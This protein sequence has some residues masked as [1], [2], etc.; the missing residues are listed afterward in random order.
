MISEYYELIDNDKLTN[1]KAY[2]LV[3]AYEAALNKLGRLSAQ[4]KKYRLAAEALYSGLD[5]I[6][7]DTP[8]EN[9]LRQAL[10]DQALAAGIKPFK[11]QEELLN[12]RFGKNDWYLLRT[13][14]E[15]IA[16]GACWNANRY[17]WEFEAV[18]STIE[19]AMRKLMDYTP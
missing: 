17:E 2:E 15:E 11:S 12:D 13:T 5:L 10:L 16:V 18:D 3:E 19:G 14:G 1:E 6:I 9:A 7:M 8:G 4:D